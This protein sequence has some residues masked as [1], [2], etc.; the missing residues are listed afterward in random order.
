[1]PYKDPEK[2][3]QNALER[4]RRYR[5][6]HGD[7]VRAASL[8]WYHAHKEKV[9]ERTSEYRKEHREEYSERMREYR[10]AHPEKNAEYRRTHREQINAYKRAWRAAKKNG[11]PLPPRKKREAKSVEEARFEMELEKCP[12]C[13]AAGG[14]KA[15]KKGYRCGCVTRTCKAWV[16]RPWNDTYETR[17]MAEAA[18]NEFAESYVP[19]NARE[20]RQDAPEAAEAVALPPEPAD[21]TERETEALDGELE[22]IPADEYIASALPPEADTGLKDADEAP[23][24]APDEDEGDGEADPEEPAVE[25][26]PEEPEEPAGKDE[27]MKEEE[28]Q[29]EEAGEED[30]GE[31]YA[32]FELV[33]DGIRYVCESGEEGCDGC[34]FCH[35]F[36]ARQI[37]VVQNEE[38]AAAARDL[39]GALQGQW[40]EVEEE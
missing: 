7:R 2:A 26:E 28:T 32:R 18:W 6:K 27:P 24:E 22:G 11:T 33:L 4:S 1:M 34:A 12:I 21:A 9:A 5:E 23:D 37:C 25:E 29:A 15:S 14:I 40:H 39:C 35:S 10:R 13:H 31:R 3:K 19:E 8:A 20:T 30:A 38:D 16:D 17:T 36:G